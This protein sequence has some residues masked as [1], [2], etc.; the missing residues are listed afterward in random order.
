M[1][2]Q[3]PWLHIMHT[4]SRLHHLRKDQLHLA[5]RVQQLLPVLGQFD[6]PARPFED[7]GGDGSGYGGGEGCTG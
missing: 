7:V 4:R 5:G 2:P 3:R 1:I 6:V